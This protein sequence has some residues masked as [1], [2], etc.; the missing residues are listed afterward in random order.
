MAGFN[1]TSDSN[2]MAIHPTIIN[3][4]N[5]ATSPVVKEIQ[6]LRERDKSGE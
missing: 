4:P 6:K 2:I 1:G 3:N 5:T